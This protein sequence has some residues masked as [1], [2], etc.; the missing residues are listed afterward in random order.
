MKVA[1][2]LILE[3]DNKY[4]LLR[5]LLHIENEISNYKNNVFCRMW[6]LVCVKE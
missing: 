3:Q 5:I 1:V 2:H 4:L 6:F